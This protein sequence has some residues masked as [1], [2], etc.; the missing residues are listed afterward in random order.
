VIVGIQTFLDYT[1]IRLAAEKRESRFTLVNTES[2]ETVRM[3]DNKC[4]VVQM[5]SGARFYAELSEEQVRALFQD[6]D[7]VRA[8]K[9]LG[10]LRA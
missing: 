7:D 2:L 8:E 3:L 4:A 5:L 9:M 10:R 1:D 6:A